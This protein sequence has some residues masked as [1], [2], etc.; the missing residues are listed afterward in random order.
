MIFTRGEIVY[1][2]KNETGALLVKIVFY[3]FEELIGNLVQIVIGSDNW[4]HSTTVAHVVI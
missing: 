1:L 2:K 3:F 4:T